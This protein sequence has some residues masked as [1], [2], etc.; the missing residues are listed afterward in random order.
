MKMK[1]SRTQSDRNLAGGPKNVKDANDEK[2]ERIKGMQKQKMIKIKSKDW[3]KVQVGDEDLWDAEGCICVVEDEAG[4]ELTQIGLGFQVA[5]VK[6]SL[7]AVDRVVE[8]RNV[9]Q[10]GPKEEDNFVMNRN[11]KEKILMRK[12]GKSYVI[13]TKLKDG[14]WT[15][16][17][18]DSA[19]EES[20]C[21]KEWA[22][23]Y[24][25]KLVKEGRQLRLVNAS[26]GPIKHYGQRDMPVHAC[27][28]FQ[29]P[30][31]C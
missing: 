5:D 8:K 10:F 2:D 17:T 6:N 9:V 24:E 16:V 18:V 30:G 14:Y 28:C 29:R 13:D 23:M 19:A 27:L 4:K 7:L 1:H 11:S 21:P 15:K 12:K 22:K 20:V 3:K 26:W 31:S 25:M